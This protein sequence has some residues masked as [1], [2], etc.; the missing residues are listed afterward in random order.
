MILAIHG[1][2]EFSDYNIFL[3]GMGVALRD[4]D[5]EDNDF[6]VYSLGP[7]NIN[8]F[9]LEFM[10]INERSLK[11]YGVKPKFQKMPMSWAKSNIHD[12]DYMLYFAAPKQPL[13]DLVKLAEAK[14]VE[15]GVYRY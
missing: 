8:T 2:R 11:A 6:I 13:S 1:T 14:D 15:V 3:R 4:K 9:A 7:N 12:I 10:N 5:P